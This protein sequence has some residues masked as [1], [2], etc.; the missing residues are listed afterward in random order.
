MDMDLMIKRNKTKSIL[1]INKEKKDLK[2]FDQEF[3]LTKNY[4]KKLQKKPTFFCQKEDVK[5]NIDLILQN[6]KHDAYENIV[7]ITAKFWNSNN[8]NRKNIFNKIDVKST[9]RY[10]Q[11]NGIKYV[12]V[13][14]N[15][16]TKIPNRI[17]HIDNHGNKINNIANNSN[18]TSNRKKRII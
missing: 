10:M 16:L 12:S 5:K 13:N 14:L 15:I 3:D 11:N 1:N 18:N 2:D 17:V 6:N 8:Q 9:N 7:P 4:L